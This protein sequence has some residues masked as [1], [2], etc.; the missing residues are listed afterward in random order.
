MS[1]S[2]LAGIPGS[3]KT[4][5]AV[6]QIYN[7]FLK[8]NNNDKKGIFSSKKEK[9]KEYDYLYTNINEFNFNLD[10]RFLKYEHDLF[11]EKINILY[12]LYISNANDNE[13]IEKAKELKLYNSLIVIDECHNFYNNEDEILVWFLTYHRHLY[14]DVFMIT[15]DLSLVSTR[16]KT[17]AEFFYQALPNAKKIN[18]SK[19]KYRQFISY[20][21]Y[22]SDKIND[23]TLPAQKEV[24]SLYV[25]GAKNNS[26]S[27][28]NRYLFVSSLLL[29]LFIFLLSLLKNYIFSSSD[30]KET[31]EKLTNNNQIS[32]SNIYYNNISDINNNNMQYLNNLNS[33]SINKENSNNLFIYKIFCFNKSICKIDNEVTISYK[34][35]KYIAE[36]SNYLYFDEVLENDKNYTQTTLI[37]DYE[38]F[39]NLKKKGKKDEESKLN[40][41]SF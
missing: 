10:E 6:Y 39:K 32:S 27:V 9:V 31:N 13:L 23:F 36:N 25:S 41:F 40:T 20:K 28:I 1:I 24:F 26:K 12:S 11:Y 21:M 38:I 17:I 2:F 14:I 30:N 37:Y 5:Y 7:T 18:T 3:G 19:F 4:Y 29:I 15:Q 22:K 33:F 8:D 35:F 16:Y 34:A